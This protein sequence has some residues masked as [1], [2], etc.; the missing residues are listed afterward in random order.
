MLGGAWTCLR[1]RVERRAPPRVQALALNPGPPKLSRRLV[2]SFLQNEAVAPGQQGPGS[3]PW[4]SCCCPLARGRLQSGRMGVSADAASRME[5][6]PLDQITL[7]GGL[8][9]AAAS[10]PAQLVPKATV[11]LGG[12]MKESPSCQGARW[13]LEDQ[14]VHTV[15]RQQPRNH[16]SPWAT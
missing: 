15:R 16:T 4:L 7:G 2:F 14:V 12:H 6:R 3:A 8:V 11:S 10:L 5:Q 13:P 9:G 1:S